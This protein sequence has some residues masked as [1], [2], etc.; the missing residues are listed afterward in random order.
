MLSCSA[1]PVAV[2]GSKI[3]NALWLVIVF[4]LLTIKPLF[5][6]IE[7]DKTKGQNEG[8][9]EENSEGKIEELV[10]GNTIKRDILPKKQEKTEKHDL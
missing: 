4:N 8:T 1:E 10:V 6:Y 3:E 5:G 2:V 7:L 9:L